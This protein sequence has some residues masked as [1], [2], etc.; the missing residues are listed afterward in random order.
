MVEV[1]TKISGTLD[2]NNASR[3]SRDDTMLFKSLF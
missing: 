2:V 1:D 3:L